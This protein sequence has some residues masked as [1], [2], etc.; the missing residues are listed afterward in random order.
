MNT[1][2]NLSQA[3]RDK[4][5]SSVEL[6]T[7]YLA[8]IKNSK[9][10]AYISV[11]ENEALTSAKLADEKLA[12]GEANSLCGIPYGLKDLFNFEKTTT[13][14]GSK[15]LENFIS[16]FN[17]TVSQKLIASDAVLLGKTNLDEFAMG[18]ANDTSHYGTVKNPWDENKI[19]G[20]SSGGS[21]AA[22]AADLC[23]FALGTDTGGS[24]RQPASMCGISGIKPTYGRVSRYGIIAYASSLDQAGPMARTAQDCAL[25]LNAISGFDVK[26]S[27]SSELKTPDFT[28]NLAQDL[29]GLKIGVPTEYFAEGLDNAVAE[30]V[31][32]AI[33]EY[34]KLGATIVDVHLPNLK[35]SIPA[36]YII[37]PSEASSNLS[38]YDGVRYGYRADNPSDLED[39]YVRSRSQGFGF[40]TQKRIM[41]G[42]YALSEGY[43]DAY[44]LK[45]QKVRRLVADDFN[46][47][48]KE[49]DVLMGPVSPTPAWDIGSVKDAT[50]MYLADIYT[51]G[52]NLAGLPAMSIPCGLAD[53]MPVGLHII[54]KAWDESKL[55]NVA[56]KFQQVTDFHLK[57][58]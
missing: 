27:T 28:A 43:Y 18:S 53:N 24:I 4:K 14:A 30:Q 52:V 46:N 51:L 54:G 49:V 16:P 3:F 38:R 20:G 55:L 31:Q 8:K 57:T 19:A 17:A 41:V 58:P 36:Y 10:N 35:N 48:F 21:A 42:T 2:T 5:I 37:A 26:D 6:T 25:V 40:E 11:N 45:A 12:N 32:N 33:K 15:I 34:E 9:L 7:D 47:A 44:Y 39:L 56:H 50:Q 22:V 1:I 13:T 29:T 23:A